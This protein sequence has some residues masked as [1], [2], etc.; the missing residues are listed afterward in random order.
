MTRHVLDIVEN[1]LAT[2]GYDIK[3]RDNMSG[4]IIIR[5]K[6]VDQDLTIYV[7]ETPS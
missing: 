5:D 6:A 2:A 1:A 4:E 3:S 7:T